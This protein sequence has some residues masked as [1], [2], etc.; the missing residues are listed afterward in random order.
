MRPVIGGIHND[1]VVSDAQFVELAEHAAAPGMP[2]LVSPVR[3]GFCPV[4]NAARPA[5]Q[6][7]WP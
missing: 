6:L 5:V 1:R 7:C 2:T 4:M 3:I